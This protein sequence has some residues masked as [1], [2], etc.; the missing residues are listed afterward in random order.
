MK[1]IRCTTSICGA[2]SGGKPSQVRT[3]RECLVSK[4][5]SVVHRSSICFPFH[6]QN[7][8]PWSSGK[9][10]AC[11]AGDPGSIPGG[12]ISFCP[13]SPPLPSGNFS[14]VDGSA[15]ALLLAT[16]AKCNLSWVVGASCHTLTVASLLPLVVSATVHKEL[17]T[18]WGEEGYSTPSKFKQII[19]ELHKY[20]LRI[21]NGRA[22]KE[23]SQ[24]KNPILFLFV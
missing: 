22:R 7:K 8:H 17:T 5:A 21:P 11:H 6:R 10:S 13:S 16:S 4:P 23:L 1:K 12:C 20:D 19:I 15:E 3:E 9:I 18:R 24:K 2:K 14:Q